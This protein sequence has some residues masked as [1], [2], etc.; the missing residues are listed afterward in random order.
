MR[1]LA[2]L[3][4]CA[5]ALLCV[6]WTPVDP[7]SERAAGTITIAGVVRDAS[8][9]LIEGAEVRLWKA[10]SGDDGYLT[11]ATDSKG[12]FNFSVSATTGRLELLA[13]KSG[14]A[15]VGGQIAIGVTEG[16]ATRGGLAFWVT[17]AGVYDTFTLTLTN[18]GAPT[19]TPTPRPTLP[20]T[21]TNLPIIL[22]PTPL[23]SPT[24]EPS[25]PPVI[26]PPHLFTLVTIAQDGT[27]LSHVWVWVEHAEGTAI[28]G[29]FTDVNG[30]ARLDA[31]AYEGP[32]NPYVTPPIGWRCLSVYID[33]DDWYEPAPTP[34]GG[35][36]LCE[37]CF[38]LP[39]VAGVTT[40]TWTLAP[41]A[42]VTQTPSPVPTMTYTPLPPTLTPTATNTPTPSPMPTPRGESL[43]VAVADVTDGGGGYS[44][45]HALIGVP[46]T[47]YSGSIVWTQ[48][49][50][51]LTDYGRM[52]Y[53]DFAHA[54]LIWPLEIHVA[55][56]GYTQVGVVAYGATSL[57]LAPFRVQ[58][59]WTGEETEAVV[60]VLVQ[61][62]APT[63]TPVGS[64]EPVEVI[65]VC[66]DL[67]RW[68]DG[69]WTLDAVTITPG[70]GEAK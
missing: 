45:A 42:V 41:D 49:T 6:G 67:V 11:K 43:S 35:N 2:L 31:P 51:D 56:N 36:R 34:V 58:L 29:A 4:L 19:A 68:S 64:P 7:D 22:T 14:Y 37:R 17:L 1:R 53:A 59:D 30:V 38:W 48:N 15:W 5:L 3:L 33:G 47:L 69:H 8:G 55:L 61:R 46:V 9:R 39:L 44:S 24:P 21:P 25:P 70:M 26:Y 62:T 20:P 23:L 66:G 13:L 57:T 28:V 27:P 63:A 65:H 12:R 40:I 16:A 52:G 32:Y 54:G 18:E 50:H 60:I 10:T